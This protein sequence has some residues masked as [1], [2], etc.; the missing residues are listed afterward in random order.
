MPAVY[1][2]GR[3]LELRFPDNA[4][5]RYDHGDLRLVAPPDLVDDLAQ[6]RDF[7]GPHRVHLPRPPP[8]IRSAAVK[9]W[10]TGAS[11]TCIEPTEEARSY[12]AMHVR[13]SLSVPSNASSSLS[14]RFIAAALDQAGPVVVAALLIHTR[15]MAMAIIGPF[16][17]AMFRP[18]NCR[19]GTKP[20]L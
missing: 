10:S 14:N 20:L 5:Q 13:S 18:V 7:V 8:Q 4:V 16:V 11:A 19:F 6:A 17:P 12:A 2:T 1:P 15:A 3:P 9:A